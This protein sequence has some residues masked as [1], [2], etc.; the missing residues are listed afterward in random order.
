MDA[1]RELAAVM[2]R[3]RGPG[4][5]PWDREQTHRSLA[6]Y[7]IEEAYE[8]ADALEQGDTAAAVEELG[9]VLLQIVFHAQIGRE[10]G[11]YDLEVIA[12]RLVEKLVRRHPHVFG[13]VVV[14]GAAEV[15][16]NWEAIKEGE[17]ASQ[18]AEQA[19]PSLMDGVPLALPALARADAVQR[20]AARV[21]FDW[22]DPSGPRAKVDEELGELDREL[23][24]GAS[25]GAARELGDL[26]FSVVNLARKTSIDAEAALREAVRR[27][28]DRFRQIERSAV[29]GGKRLDEMDLAQLD[30][31]WDEAKARE[32][33][34]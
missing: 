17:R 9:D 25:E 26:L 12:R 20:R 1:V 22:A 11:A 21:G 18:S 5:C 13:D 23:E 30:R 27:F 33:E 16:A 10:E 34:P 31:L 32:T 28:E 2:E 8:A 19:P 15:V 7:L 24:A 14:A 6:R 4:G 29:A 3:L